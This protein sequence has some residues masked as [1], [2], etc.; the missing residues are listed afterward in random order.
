[1][2]ALGRDEPLPAF[3]PE[4]LECEVPAPDPEDPEDE[5]EDAGPDAAG[6]LPDEGAAGAACRLPAPAVLPE[7]ALPEP[8][9]PPL[10]PPPPPT[11]VEPSTAWSPPPGPA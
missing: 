8:P 4:C 5:D 2:L 10:L 1:V 7:P 9:E 11:T 6:A 3:E